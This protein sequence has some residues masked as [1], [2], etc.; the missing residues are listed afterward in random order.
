LLQ[1]Q[2]MEDAAVDFRHNSSQKNRF[3]KI[4]KSAGTVSE[5][6]TRLRIFEKQ[7]G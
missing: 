1:T 4:D 5:S 6:E 2:G 7:R 3:S